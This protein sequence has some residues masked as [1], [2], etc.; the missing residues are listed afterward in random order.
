MPFNWKI[1]ASWNGLYIGS[2]L[3]MGIGKEEQISTM[4]GT[5][6]PQAREVVSKWIASKNPRND[7]SQHSTYT[8]WPYFDADLWCG[9]CLAASAVQ[10][11][12]RREVMVFPAWSLADSPRY[13]GT[14]KL[15]LSGLLPNRRF[16][17]VK[18]RVFILWLWLCGGV[19]IGYLSDNRQQSFISFHFIHSLWIART[20]LETKQVHGRASI[21]RLL[22]NLFSQRLVVRG[23]GNESRCYI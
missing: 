13:L 9:V 8:S 22:D 17:C 10:Q 21:D 19:W 2:G 12:L 6:T 3:G 11:V 5:S 18:R 20:N 16:F 23:M 1:I 7:V 14:A 4:K 15:R